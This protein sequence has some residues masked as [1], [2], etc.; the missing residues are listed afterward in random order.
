MYCL[1]V[2]I[3]VLFAVVLCLVSLAAAQDIAMGSEPKAGEK[4]IGV[5]ANESQKGYTAKDELGDNRYA[6]IIGIDEYQDKDIPTLSKCVR[7]AEEIRKTL[8]DPSV[9]GIPKE[10]IQFLT[11]SEATT[12]QIKIA[13]SDLKRCPKGST[14][15]V[16]YSGHGGKVG[17]DGYWVTYDADIDH[18]DGTG[19]S[20]DNVS[21]FLSNI[22]S[23]KI[24]CLIDC[25]YAGAMESGSKDILTGVDA[26]LDKFTGKGRAFIMAAGKD[27][28]AKEDDFS[29]HS[30]FT[31]LII[32]GL[33]GKADEG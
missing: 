1:A 12:R 26:L 4:A 28:T 11:N 18:L 16:F 25:C 24:V 2:K 14:V 15:Y 10:N 13:F 20:N 21:Q 3:R 9:C 6:L 19:L 23:E 31:R 7:D 30:I 17:D 27:Q 33:K 5:T 22:Q 29:D 32:E 8:A